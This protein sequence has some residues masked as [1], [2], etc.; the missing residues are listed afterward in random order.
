[1]LCLESIGCLDFVFG[2]ENFEPFLPSMVPI[3]L[4]FQEIIVKFGPPCHLPQ[5]HWLHGPICLSFVK[6]Q[7]SNH[8]IKFDVTY[9][10]LHSNYSKNHR[11]L[12]NLMYSI[13]FDKMGDV[14]MVRSK[15]HTTI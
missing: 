9:L 7:T 13:K 1:L 3:V 6:W 10:T 15:V 4:F 5:F 11:E 14:A 2:K 8:C 12:C